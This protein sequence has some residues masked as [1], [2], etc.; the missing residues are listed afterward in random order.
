[1]WS[2][3]LAAVGYLGFALWSGWRDVAAAVG[4][5][6]LPGVL[7]ALVLSLVNYALRFI[8]W[9]SYLRATGHRVAWRLSLKIYLA[10]FAL[11]ATP[12]KAGEALRAVLLARWGIPYATSL[13]A[14]LS[15]RVSDLL[16]IVLL[17]LFGLAVYPATQPLIA[18]GA[19]VVVAAFVLL[20]SG[21]LLQRLQGPAR[22]TLLQARRCHTPLLL[23]AASA[24]S[25]TGWA[26][27]A[28]A[29]H[30]ILVWMKV[31]LPLAFAI[32]VFATSMLA[33]ALS[34]M[35]GG[36]GGTEA[37]M[38]GLLMWKGTGSTEA[39]AATLLIR[40]TTLW[41]AVGIGT[42]TLARHGGLVPAQHST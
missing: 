39:I 12:G 31:D 33:G 42:L 4:E 1:M 36:L 17:A 6:G 23:I 9:Q 18:V 11:T 25:L 3:V 29:F 41:F 21:A 8:R 15:E 40:L 30:L 26:A 10:G 37:V 14:F 38:V 13:A 22:E 34:F 19:G 20:H 2:A 32:F 24:L 35:P 27:E 5:V 16:A 28:F 7:I